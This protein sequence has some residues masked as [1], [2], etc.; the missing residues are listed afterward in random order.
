LA[1]VII[2]IIRNAALLAVWAR[3]E[4]FLQLESEITRAEV[5]KKTAIPNKSVKLNPK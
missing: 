2:L 5:M 1:V 4:T 3:L